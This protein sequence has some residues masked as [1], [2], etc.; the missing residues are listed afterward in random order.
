MAPQDDVSRAVGAYLRRLR[1]E[2]GLSLAQVVELLSRDDVMLSV[3]T[4]SRAEQGASVLRVDVAELLVERLGGTF[5]ELAEVIRG[6]RLRSSID[7]PDAHLP[8]EPV[9]A[10]QAAREI[11]V[12]GRYRE[13]MS[14]LEMLAEALETGRYA[15]ADPSLLPSVRIDLGDVYR[16][17]GMY[18]RGLR[19]L[20]LAVRDPT[21]APEDAFRARILL[22]AWCAATDTP[23][24]GLALADHLRERLDGRTEGWMTGLARAVLGIAELARG[25]HRA[26]GEDLLVA[27]RIYRD[28]DR[29]RD[30]LRLRAP[31]AEA[32][33]GLG[34]G[35]Q[36]FRLLEEAVARAAELRLVA[37]ET[38]LTRRLAD[39]HR[40]DGRL[41][42]A[43]RTYARAAH[44]ARR[45]GMTDELFL[46]LHGSWKC[47]LAEGAAARTRREAAALRRLARELDPR[48]PAVAEFLAA[49]RS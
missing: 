20:L 21:I 24:L 31:L 45:I 46:A 34:R 2:A 33:H 44:L 49:R 27:S 9:D 39:L 37:L 38:F 1:Q 40:A 36:A 35:L 41:A 15:H 14:R 42:T 4:L 29:P 43:R 17:L 11:I 28:L 12:T 5:E 3:A 26:A 47:A 6:A 8:G 23:H 10:R 48:M 30:H 7:E 13:G 19:V 25:N 22:L 32:L 18:E 16:R